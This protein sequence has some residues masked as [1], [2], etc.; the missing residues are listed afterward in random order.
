MKLSF[1]LLALL[2]IMPVN[3]LK[4]ILIICHE[5]FWFS[6][7]SFELICHDSYYSHL[8]FMFFRVIK[9]MWS[10]C[11]CLWQRL[12]HQGFLWKSLFIKI[13]LGIVN[14]WLSSRKVFFGFKFSYKNNVAQLCTSLMFAINEQRS[15]SSKIGSRQKINKLL[16]N[17]MLK[18]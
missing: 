13:W 18:I 9:E 8:L 1:L 5:V 15:S 6:F 12:L 10:F 4:S 14:R 2:Y 16:C 17:F 11:E 3:S 7:S